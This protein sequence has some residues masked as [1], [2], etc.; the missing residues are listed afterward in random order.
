VLAA[1]P[2]SVPRIHPGRRANSQKLPSD[3]HT[4][5]HAYKRIKIKILILITLIFREKREKKSLHLL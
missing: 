4:T 3:L 5:P 2:V 1:K